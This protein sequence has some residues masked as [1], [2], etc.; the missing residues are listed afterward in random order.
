MQKIRYW[1]SLN[2]KMLTP[3]NSLLIGYDQLNTLPLVPCSDPPYMKAA[4]IPGVLMQSIGIVDKNYQDVFDGDIIE[5]VDLHDDRQIGSI[6][7]S[8]GSFQIATTDERPVP[9]KDRFRFWNDGTHHWY[10]LEQLARNEIEILGNIYENSI[11]NFKV[12]KVDYDIKAIYLFPNKM[13][14][15]FDNSNQQIPELQGKYT[16]KFHKRLLF[17]A[18]KE[19][20]WF[21]FDHLHN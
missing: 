4:A 17:F 9:D 3:D 19:T 10:S 14:A 5:F 21:G 2:K 1:D 12:E 7:F 11:A 18:N 8:Y 15:T 13:I 16:P 20:E 6:Y